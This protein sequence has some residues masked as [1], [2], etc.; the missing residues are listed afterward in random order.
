MNK[1]KKKVL[2]VIPDKESHDFLEKFFTGLDFEVDSA[3][4]A[5]L[6]WNRIGRGKYSIIIC[7]DSL[8][9]MDS[10]N[11][12][13]N[14]RKVYPQIPI[15]LTTDYGCTLQSMQQA[16]IAGANECMVKPLNSNQAGE[17]LIRH[18]RRQATYG[19]M[20]GGC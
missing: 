16:W 15:A 10:L 8:P 3:S 12:I 11:F 7:D 1:E 19:S 2:L 6:A 14:V 20:L 9:D 5:M 4:S 13:R 17:F 18:Y